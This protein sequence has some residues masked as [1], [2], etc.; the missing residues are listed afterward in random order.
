VDFVVFM[1][2]VVKQCKG[3]YRCRM[4]SHGPFPF[5]IVHSSNND[6]GDCATCQV[7]MAGRAT[8]PCVAK[9]PEAPKLKSLQEK[10]LEIQ[11]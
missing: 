5:S 7:F 10:G 11:P 6:R 2:T 9:V 3:I 4:F 8:N 1:V